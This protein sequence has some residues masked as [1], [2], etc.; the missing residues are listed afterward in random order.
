MSDSVT[1]RRS[2]DSGR[3]RPRSRSP[4]PRG[5]RWEEDSRRSRT[6]HRSHDSPRGESGPRARPSGTND[7]FPS[8]LADIGTTSTLSHQTFSHPFVSQ[9]TSLF[10]PVVSQPASLFQPGTVQTLE[11]GRHRGRRTCSTTRGR[12]TLTASPSQSSQGHRVS[13][14]GQAN[15]IWGQS[16][17]LGTQMKLPAGLLSSL[18]GH[19]CPRETQTLQWW[20]S[21]RRAMSVP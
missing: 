16:R 10:H 6:S 2:E 13:P 1:M 7:N 5:R 8:P 3:R 19:S 12:Y 11:L 20:E 18:F 14:T 21:D 9:T 17:H 15:S 4:S